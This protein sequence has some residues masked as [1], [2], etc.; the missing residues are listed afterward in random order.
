M[1]ARLDG[2]ADLQ[3]RVR[4][5]HVQLPL[6]VA[7]NLAVPGQ[8]PRRAFALATDRE[9][10]DP[11]AIDPQVELLW[12]THAND[13]VVDLPS[14]PHFEEILAIE[15]EVVPDRDAASGTER[16]VLTDANVLLQELR[17][18]IDRRTGSS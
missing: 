1:G 17:D 18:L 16:H 5:V 8:R 3:A 9:P 10:L 14:Q 15:R 11:L 6:R 2:R 4:R 12:M 7:D 13:V